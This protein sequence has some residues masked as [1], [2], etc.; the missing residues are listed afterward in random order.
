M[1]ES[2]C[3][4][5]IDISG[6]MESRMDELKEA[7]KLLVWEQIYKENIHF[8]MI[9]FSS[10]IQ[11]WRDH[12]VDPTESLCHEAI[13]WVDSLECDGN[14]NTLLALQV[15]L[16]MDDKLEAVY[17]LSDGKPDCSTTTL[18]EWLNNWAV[19]R[20]SSVTNRKRIVINTISF[21][22]EDE[23]ANAFLQQL[24]HQ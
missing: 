19:E 16:N 9:A 12:L 24:A 22:C 8:N 21:N 15:G 4:V 17:L 7:L 11:C 10:S 14:T 13:A 3:V 20:Q 1:V 2:H 5:L 18:L 6:S 23:T